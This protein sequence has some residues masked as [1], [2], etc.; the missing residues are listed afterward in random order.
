MPSPARTLAVASWFGVGVATA[1]VLTL[2]AEVMA[3]GMLAAGL[4]GLAW[5]FLTHHPAPAEPASDGACP[6]CDHPF[7]EL[8]HACYGVRDSESELVG[9]RHA[10]DDRRPVWD[11]DV[12]GAPE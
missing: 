7:G 9:D 6:V 5:G 10:S 3:A 1:G 8:R 4:L 11:A 12:M 2:D